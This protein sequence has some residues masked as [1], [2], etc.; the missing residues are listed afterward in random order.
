MRKLHPAGVA[1]A[2]IPAPIPAPHFTIEMVRAALSTFGPGSGA[3]LFGYKPVLLQQ[4]MRLESS[5]F[6]AALVRAV[7]VLAD[8][9][10]PAFLK[11][12]L[13]GGVS[14]ALEK[15]GT[16]VRPLCCGDPIRRL[17]GKCFCIAGKD[18]IT[19]AFRSRNYGVGCPGGVEVVAHSL[20]DVLARHSGSKMALLKIDFRNAF[21]EIKR[22]HFVK[23]A[24]TM[25]PSRSRWTSWCYGTPSML[26]YDHQHIIESMC[27]VQQGDPLG[28]LYFCCGIMGLVNEINQLGPIYNKWYMDDGGIVGDVDLLLKVWDLLQ[29]RG[30]EMGLYLNP[31]K[32]EWSWLDASCPLPC[33]IRLPDVDEE[34]QVKLVAT[35]EIQMLGVPLGSVEFVDEFVRRK[36]LGRLD[37][38]ME[39][40]VEFEDSQAAMYLLRISYGIVRAV[41]FMRTT[42]LVQWQPHAV[43]FDAK[44]R[45]TAEQILGR[46]L[47]SYR[48]A[49]IST[50]LG[51]LASGAPWITRTWPSQL[52]GTSPSPRQ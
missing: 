34:A 50:R 48:Q 31:S 8:G 36:L 35:S 15:S 44:V 32:C 24:H 42:P 33:P 28:P 46:P 5:T 18:D 2:P 21:N 9:R 30:P 25:F 49:S 16:S 23:A 10:A 41:H 38:T 4:C 22:D 11:R 37:S 1:P 45:D 3:G 29:S 52:A 14:I 51:G 39:K 12:F 17:V 20:R 6:G 43:Q 47:E 19:E 40:L 7:N 13:A 27:G 26:L